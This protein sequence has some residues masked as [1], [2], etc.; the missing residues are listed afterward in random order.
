MSRLYLTE[1]GPVFASRFTLRTNEFDIRGYCRCP[2]CGSQVAVSSRACRE[3]DLTYEN[4]EGVIGLV[5]DDCGETYQPELHALQ[6]F[7]K[8]MP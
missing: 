6:L 4:E 7:A 5:C 2:L 8:T 3:V 1:N